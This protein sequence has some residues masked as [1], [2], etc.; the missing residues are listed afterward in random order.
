MSDGKLNIKAPDEKIMIKTYLKKMPWFYNLNA[1]IKSRTTK[2]QYLKMVAYY[3]SK[4]EIGSFKVLLSN[5]L[6]DRLEKL[7]RLDRPPNILFLGTD[8]MQDR[9]GTIQALERMGN[10]T[11]FTQADKS[12]GQ[13][14]PGPLKERARANSKR[15]LEM[16]QQLSAEGNPPDILIAQTWGSLIDGA[17][18]SKI[19]NDY[20]TVIINIAMDDRH[21]YRGVKIN[22]TW[23]GTS[24]LIPH[25]DLA[26]TAAPEC[27]AWYLKEGCPALFF[28]EASDPDIFYPMP[29]LPKTHDVC[30]V[31]G[32]Y[33]I[34]KKIVEA[35][36]IRGIKVAAYGNGWPNGRIAI[37]K[38]PELFA[39]SRIILGIGTIGH[40]T[41]FYSLKMRD[42]DA[43]MSG[44]FY[45]THYNPDLENL[46]VIGKEIETYRTPKECAE[47]VVYYLNHPE[48]A[49]AIGRAGRLLAEREH[50]S[51][52]RFS[53]LLEFLIC[54]CDAGAI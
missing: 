27:V 44:S 23:S 15:L 45:L 24:A 32:C 34:R 18:L 36:E 2:K 11:Y 31:G 33:G 7:R 9:S 47:E 53:G 39:Q 49:E 46:F 26:L 30:F 50:T 28:P 13:N 35:I 25:I 1:R 38:V 41:D 5:R 4:K 42:F 54:H 8:E 19:R 10:L 3:A 12:Y 51:E 22:S 20:G 14:Y 6:G 16:V 29:E 48:K 21:Q 37:E 52:R 17:V 43:P 40:C